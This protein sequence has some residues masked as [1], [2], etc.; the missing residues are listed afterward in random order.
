MKY[1][2]AT[3][4]LFTAGFVNADYV[5]VPNKTK[6]LIEYELE[7]PY[8]HASVFVSTVEVPI[9]E[10]SIDGKT[11]PEAQNILARYREVDYHS[12]V[13][14]R[15]A[16]SPSLL[17]VQFRCKSEADSWSI[18]R[19]VISEHKVKEVDSDGCAHDT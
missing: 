9:L 11:V 5:I 7:P 10:I 2:W 19:I 1:A 12:A 4:I 14:A 3:L 6:S 18:I 17:V 8:K 13:L 16:Y 15:S